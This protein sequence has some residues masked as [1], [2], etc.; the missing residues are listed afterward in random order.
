MSFFPAKFTSYGALYV[1]YYPS[2]GTGQYAKHHAWSYGQFTSKSISCKKLTI[3]DTKITSN[4][5]T[6]VENWLVV[7]EIK[8]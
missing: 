3:N 5:N 8:M 2:E 1:Q 7:V 6:V 4:T